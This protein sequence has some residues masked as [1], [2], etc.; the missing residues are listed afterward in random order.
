M[1]FTRYR[2]YTEKVEVWINLR[3]IST[4]DPDT[5]GCTIVLR[6]NNTIHVEM[7]FAS[8]VKELDALR[9]ASIAH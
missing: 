7:S 5:E 2:H 3:D 9:E 8:V 1:L 4:V 6:N